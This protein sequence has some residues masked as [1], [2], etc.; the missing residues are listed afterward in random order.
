MRGL[1]Y[2]LVVTISALSFLSGII[3]AHL[4]RGQ[5]AYEQL[6]NS[7]ITGI[8][9][10]LSLGLIITIIFEVVQLLA[11]RQKDKKVEKEKA[12][13]NLQKHTADLKPILEKWAK[14]F[15]ISPTE[16]LFSLVKQH[17]PLFGE[18]D[19]VRSQCNDLQ[20]N[21]SRYIRTIIKQASAD[22]PEL[23]AE[24]LGWIEN[25]LGKSGIF[26]SALKNRS[27]T[28]IKYALSRQT[29]SGSVKAEYLVGTEEK[30][31][32]LA[33]TLND[34][35]VDSHLKEMDENLKSL[36]TRFHE[37]QQ[38]LQKKVNSAIDEITYGVK[39][40]DRI[41]AG[42]CDRCID[43]KNKWHIN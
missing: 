29:E 18:L 27:V 41:L 12:I 43:V 31:K 28:P 8:S 5:L 24:T 42:K 34:L 25:D 39:G 11:Q 9:A 7:I 32:A 15:Q 26:V 22:F 14:E 30:V 4:M 35:R 33:K 1:K 16:Y 13:A 23:D 3:F 6:I 2:I 19:N 10:G 37:L 17:I 40:E 21:I 38:T 36:L 20:K